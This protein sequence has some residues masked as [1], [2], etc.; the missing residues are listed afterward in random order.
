MANSNEIRKLRNLITTETRRALNESHRRGRPSLR[1]LLEAEG[2]KVA[3]EGGGKV[4]WEDNY[5]SFV[6]ALG[7]NIKDPK[8]KAFI[9]AGKLDGDE[10]DDKFKFS[11]T[12]LPVSGLTPTQ[13]EIDI[14]GS[15]KWALKDAK[16]FLGYVNSDGPFSPGG[17]IVTFNGKYVIDGHH[18]WSQVY[19]C[20]KNAKISATDAQI[21]GLEPLEVLKAMQASIA[22][23]TG[24]V[25][26][27]SVKGTNLLKADKGA[28]DSFLDGMLKDDFVATVKADEG[29]VAKMKEASG[30]S[31]DDTKQLV[32]DYIWSNVESM[33]ETSQAI[34]GAPKRD[35][36]PQTDNVDW[37]DPL[38]QGLIDVKPPH[39]KAGGGQASQK[40]S[41]N[42]R[43]VVLE[44]WQK[45]AG[46]IKS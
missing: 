34:S 25:P 5:E 12:D 46:I 16:T 9:S 6:S 7:S 1:R 41:L 22:Y 20:N 38:A 30:S 37:K 45:L 14:N 19:C 43:G 24:G 42:R 17:K 15:L 35:F 36:M 29:A 8:T 13:N 39:G 28:I 18:R 21:E 44:R 23:A 3:P 33:K 26:T 10:S 31:S 32:K 27:Q 40:E 11:D 4:S 2:D